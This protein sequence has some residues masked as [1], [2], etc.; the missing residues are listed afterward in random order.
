MLK[1]LERSIA[2]LDRRVV[3]VA[4]TEAPAPIA[5]ENVTVD[6]VE[7]RR[8]LREM[9]QLR[10]KVYLEDGALQPDHLTEEGLH[11]TPEDLAS[12]HLL[13][14]NA[15][16]KVTACIWYMPHSDHASFDR[17]RVK[18][19]PLA[20]SPRWRHKVAAAV[21]SEIEL[22]RREDLTLAEVGGWAVARENRCSAEGLLLALAGYSMGTM[23]GGALGI[24]TATVRNSS[25]AILRRLGGR[26]LETDGTII[27]PYYDP[28]YDCDMEL[29]RFDTRR[30]ASKYAGVIEQLA[31]K[32]AKV[33]TITALPSYF[34]GRLAPPV[35]WESAAAALSAA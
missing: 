34:E 24:T 22:A 9:Q 31:Q 27:P 16:R 2:T 32:L 17:L 33:P 25:A 19:C 26:H 5:F 23:L 20:Q 14:L 4:P 11:Q 12:W 18:Q 8:L 7:C 10:G 35:G 13:F 29:L 1:G 21:G 30:P 15:A 6:P 3:L 28:N